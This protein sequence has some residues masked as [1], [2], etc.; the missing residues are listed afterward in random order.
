MVIAITVALAE[1]GLTRPDMSGY[2]KIP[3]VRTL[4]AMPAILKK[5]RRVVCKEGLKSR[6]V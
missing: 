5:D 6:M 4:K 1:F 2:K 3:V